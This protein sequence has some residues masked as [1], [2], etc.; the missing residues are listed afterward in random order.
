MNRKLVRAITLATLL[1]VPALAGELGGVTMPDD[2]TLDGKTLVL[3]G[4]GLREK[5]VFDVY[6]A[7]LYL[8]QTTS[9]PEA[10]LSS[11]GPVRLHMHFVYKKVSAAKLVAA[12]NDGFKANA[13]DKM[14]SLQAGLDQLNSWMEEVVRGDSMI[15]TST[16]EGLEVAVKGQVKGVVPGADFARAFWSVFLGPKPPTA[17]LKNGLLGPS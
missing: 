4:M 16:P 7:G 3:N 2:V 15:F 9:D 13:G 8:E 1:A 14:A 12:W 10:I 6:V 5:F 11:D 17:P